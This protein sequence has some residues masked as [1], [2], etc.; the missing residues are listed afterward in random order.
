MRTR[1]ISAAGSLRIKS[2]TKSAR[3][4]DKV[5]DII[6]G[7]NRSENIQS[8]IEILKSTPIHGKSG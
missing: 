6:M 2:E 7:G 4:S 8:E 5:E 3:S 1:F